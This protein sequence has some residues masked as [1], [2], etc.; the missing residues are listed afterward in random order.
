[1]NKHETEHDQYDKEHQ[2]DKCSKKFS[3]QEK[4]KSHQKRIHGSMAS[5]FYCN[6]C[7]RYFK[8][9]SI[10]NTHIK[11]IIKRMYFLVK[12]VSQLSH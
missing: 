7:G 6:I 11:P 9:E 5:T 10:L 4:L 3:H 1:M 12:V 8:T 2:C